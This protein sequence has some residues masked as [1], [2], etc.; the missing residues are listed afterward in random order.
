MEIIIGIIVV[1][2]LYKIFFGASSRIRNRDAII[3][4]AVRL[5]VPEADAVDILEKQMDKLGP[6]LHITTMKGSTVADR[7]AHERMAHCI[8]A[9]YKKQVGN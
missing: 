3:G 7:P 1:F 6:M 4:A 9:I 5:G 8:N 2:V